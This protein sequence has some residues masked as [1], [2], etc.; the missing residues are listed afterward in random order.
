MTQHTRNTPSSDAGFTLIEL[1]VVILIIGI[2]AAI[3]I[4]SFIS[5]KS[6]A[7]DAGAKTVAR[8]AQTAMETYAT[9]HDGSYAGV[10]TPADLKAIEPTIDITPSNSSAYLS[11]AM[12]S[13]SGYTVVAVAGADGDQFT[14]IN[15]SSTVSHA[16]SGSGGGCDN[17]TW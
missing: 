1:L 6:K 13:S 10:N 11:S 9:D 4:P 7:D 16:C 2:L 14:V 8:T 5:Q 3:A 15:T 17:G 12:G